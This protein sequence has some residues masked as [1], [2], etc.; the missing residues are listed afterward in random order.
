MEQEG[1]EANRNNHLAHG[2]RWPFDVAE[3]PLHL[4]TLSTTTW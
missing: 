1:Q 4:S 2:L 3:P